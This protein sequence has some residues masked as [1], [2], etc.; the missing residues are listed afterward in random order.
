MDETK[1]SLEAIPTVVVDMIKTT[2]GQTV[3]DI[4]A[5]PERFVENTKKSVETYVAKDD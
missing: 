2:V 3:E 4:K 1:K 5:A